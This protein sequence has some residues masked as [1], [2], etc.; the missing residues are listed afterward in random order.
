M[1]SEVTH[2]ADRLAT[3]LVPFTAGGD[4]LDIAKVAPLNASH[5]NQTDHSFDAEIWDLI[6][7]GRGGGNLIESWK[8]MTSAAATNAARAQRYV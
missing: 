2:F 8:Q 6:P 7:L 3:L 5:Y 4:T 1:S